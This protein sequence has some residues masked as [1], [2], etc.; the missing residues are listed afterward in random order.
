MSVCLTSLY[1]FQRLASGE[2]FTAR[3][4]SCGLFHIAYPSATDPLK[5]EL[6][7]IYGQLCQDD[8]PMVRRAAASNLGKFAATVEQSHLK[9]EIMSIF[10]DLTQ[11]GTFLC[12]FDVL[13]Y[14]IVIHRLVQIVI[15]LFKSEIKYVNAYLP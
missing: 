10:D 11:D 15:Y 8:M 9:T 2:W 13:F 4:S 14:K 1:A 6:R 5:T 3:V 12:M 7:T